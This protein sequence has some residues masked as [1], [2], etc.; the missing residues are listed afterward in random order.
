[1][2]RATSRATGASAIILSAAL[3]VGAAAQDYEPPR[4]EH[5]FP[6]LQGVWS[7]ASV[8]GM[9]RPR[10]YPLVLTPE[11]AAEIEGRDFY[12]QR[13]ANE[14]DPLD[15]NAPPPE[16]GAPLPPVGNYS[17][18][19]TDPGAH[20]A[21][22]N[23]ELR[24]S[25]ITYPEDGQYPAMTEEG[26]AL[27]AAAAG[28]GRRGSGYDN[29]EERG[30]GERCILIGTGGPPLGQYLYNNN[31]QIVQTKDHLMLMAEMI[32]DVRI[33]RIDEAHR[34]DGVQPWMGDSI[35]WWEGDTLVTQT[36]HIHPEQ[37]TGRRF[38]SDDATITEKFTRVSDDQILYAF[39]IDDPSV[40]EDV[41]RG[42]MPLNRMD[43]N[44]YEY[45]CHEGNHGLRNILQGGRVADAQGV[46]QV[47]EGPREE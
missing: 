8:T 44:V 14:S 29:P 5:G 17:Y 10:G 33:F 11:Q 18:V 34:D 41:T 24:S 15:P 20:V 30:L 40:Y 6:D 23:G 47:D 4:T 26:Q 38:L 1:M 9:T 46:S 3:A 19:W 28:G 43:E 25:F 45:A 21:V 36:R 35:A 42:E 27:R 31:V 32:H 7:N 13:V 39:E 37:R 22:V 16:A 2:S 12:N